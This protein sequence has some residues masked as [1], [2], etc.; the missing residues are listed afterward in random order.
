M[1][2]QDVS[3]SSE[4]QLVALVE[5]V[6][7]FDDSASAPLRRGS[8]LTTTHHR[9]RAPSDRARL[10]GR[11]P[12]PADLAERRPLGVA[13]VAAAV[14]LALVPSDRSAA[15]HGAVGFVP[16][17]SLGALLHQVHQAGDEGRVHP[18]GGGAGGASAFSRRASDPATRAK[19]TL[20]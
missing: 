5:H 8:S 18:G 9:T 13:E 14:G 2:G 3:G 15:D 17:G 12:G 6:E 10:R 1:Y 4:L 16:A 19:T 20:E 11:R 7:R